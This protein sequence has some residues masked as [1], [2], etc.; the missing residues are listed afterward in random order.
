MAAVGLP[1]T[2]SHEVEWLFFSVVYYISLSYE[3]H[4]MI[5][6][7]SSSFN[8]PC[9]STPLRSFIRGSALSLCPLCLCGESLFVFWFRPRPLCSL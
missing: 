2:R 4:L 1:A 6:F 8:N 5:R 7:V 9:L 3:T